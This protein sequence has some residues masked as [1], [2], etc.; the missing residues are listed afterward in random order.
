MSLGLNKFS[1]QLL[2]E[3]KAKDWVFITLA[4]IAGALSWLFGFML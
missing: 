3:I 4:G 1:P 2:A